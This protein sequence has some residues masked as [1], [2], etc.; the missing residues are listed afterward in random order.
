MDDN[1]RAFLKRLMEAVC[2]TGYEED[3]AR[4]WR[5]EAEGFA[6]RT[7]SDVHGNSFAVVN[8]AGSPRVMLAG[9]IDE[10]GLMVTHIDKNGFLSFRPIGG[11]DPQI[12]PGQRVRIRT[13]QGILIGV[14]GRKA[15][16]LLEKEAREK[17]VKVKQLWVDIGARDKEEA[18]SLVRIGDPMVVDHGFATLRNDIALAR[19]FDDRIG[20]FVVLEAARRLKD[21]NPDAAVY[22]VG[23]VQE[24]I[25]LRG[26][27]TSAFGI[28]PQVGIA[29]DV[30]HATDIP[31]AASDTG[32]EGDIAMGKGPVITRGPNINRL[33]FDRM[34]NAAEAE[35]IPYQVQGAP[36]GTGTD[37]NALQLTRAGV[38]TGLIGIPNRYM[39]SPCEL[40]HL[41]DVEA[42][43]RII[44]HTV[45]GIGAD[46][47]FVLD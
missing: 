2:P 6:D 22:V 27:I 41:G 23:T 33:L 25:G 39:H 18:E 42:A 10:I 3:A 17:V 13:D 44:A 32:G 30:T 4:I 35:K 7:W 29:V 21:M 11:W 9:H 16:H 43:S 36:R 40:V 46:S 28:D 20:A 8:E 26:A 15:I 12:L 1:T 37:A 5:Q 31:D 45:A 14:V 19:A 47:S 24:E 38:A 34:V